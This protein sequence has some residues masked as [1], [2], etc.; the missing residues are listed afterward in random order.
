MAEDRAKRGSRGWFWL[1]MVAI[2]VLVAFLFGRQCG[3]VPDIPGDAPAAAAGERQIMVEASLLQLDAA[4]L[5]T[6]E[7]RRLM[8]LAMQGRLSAEGLAQAQSDQTTLMAAGTARVISNPRLVLLE[9]QPAAVGVKI[10]VPAGANTPRRTRN[11]SIEI[12][13]T[14][15]ADGLISGRYTLKAVQ[16]TGEIEH[17][18]NEIGLPLGDRALVE[19]DAVAADGET[20]V[21]TREL[22][23]SSDL[24]GGL[25]LFVKPTLIER[26]PDG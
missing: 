25:V 21:G 13:C 19:I 4:A 15:T 18:A 8:S 14:V 22:R 7:G 16:Q 23:P 24:G 26:E 17:A 2:A 1:R 3:S 20:V 6:N 11:D 12:L 5:E 9:G 10:E